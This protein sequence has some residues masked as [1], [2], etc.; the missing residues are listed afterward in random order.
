MTSTKALLRR[1][2]ARLLFGLGLAGCS[3]APVR[4]GRGPGGT[5]A[6]TGTAPDA[7]SANQKAG[8]D[9]TEAAGEAAPARKPAP[10]RW[11]LPTMPLGPP[12]EDV[13]LRF[14]SKDDQLLV[15]M[16]RGVTLRLAD[17]AVLPG[18]GCEVGL[19][20]GETPACVG[21]DRGPWTSG[22]VN[23]GGVEAWVDGEV[24]GVPNPRGEETEVTVTALLL[25]VGGVERKRTFEPGQ[26]YDGVYSF[27]SGAG[28]AP[29]WLVLHSARR[30]QALLVNLDLRG[31]KLLGRRVVRVLPLPDARLL[32]VL[33]DGFEVWDARGK[34]PAPTAKYAWRNRS[35]LALS[36]SETHVAYLPSPPPRTGDIPIYVQPLDG[37]APP[38]VVAHV[39]SPRGP[40]AKGRWEALPELEPGVRRARFLGVEG[41][42]K[43]QGSDDVVWRLRGQGMCCNLPLHPACPREWNEPKTAYCFDDAAAPAI[44][45]GADVRLRCQQIGDGEKGTT[46]PWPSCQTIFD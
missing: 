11:S 37:S 3:S 10:W 7:A 4:A 21:A 46:R 25:K 1:S 16:G 41:D 13:A 12:P 14:S 36:N 35:A 45:P 30:R 19:P 44:A 23:V 34:G 31:D 5:N 6:S 43:A 26:G 40:V 38:R 22:K 28:P 2:A 42:V 8:G 27:A 32:F 39:P 17:G 18:G 29:P 33:D 15:E 20:P 24:V 9:A